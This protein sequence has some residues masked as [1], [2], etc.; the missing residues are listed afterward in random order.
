ML[1]VY[2]VIHAGSFSHH[3]V[4]MSSL[5]E[6][7]DLYGSSAFCLSQKKGKDENSPMEIFIRFC[8]GLI[9]GPIWSKLES[10]PETKLVQK[11]VIFWQNMSTWASASDE[12]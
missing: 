6:F 1:N 9:F 8:P 5:C 3:A 11:L 7:Y 2:V 10:D 4:D 12:T